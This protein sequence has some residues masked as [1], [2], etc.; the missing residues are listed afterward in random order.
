MNG[1]ENLTSLTYS[2]YKA[3]LRLE[4]CHVNVELVL[5]STALEGNL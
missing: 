2:K 3:S 5:G 1:A 4:T